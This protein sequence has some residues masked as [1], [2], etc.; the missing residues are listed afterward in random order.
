MIQLRLHRRRFEGE[1]DVEDQAEAIESMPYRVQAQ[2]KKLVCGC[3]FKHRTTVKTGERGVPES[4]PDVKVERQR[5]LN[6]KMKLD[7][8]RMTSPGLMVI[9]HAGACA[10]SFRLEKGLCR[11]E[12]RPRHK[13]I[14]IPRRSQR[15]ITVNSLCETWTLKREHRDRRP[16]KRTEQ[17]GQLRAQEEPIDL[18]G[19]LSFKKLRLNCECRATVSATQLR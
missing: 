3:E 6:I 1:A 14:E 11:R 10:K 4:S 12:V 13:Q 2:V 17:S 9:V 19:S 8:R 15:D 16:G 5:I 7:P 18:R